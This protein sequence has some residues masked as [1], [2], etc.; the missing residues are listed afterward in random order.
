MNGLKLFQRICIHAAG[1]I[2]TEVKDY[3]PEKEHRK[4]I[5]E[6]R[7]LTFILAISAAAAIWTWHPLPILIVGLPTIYGAWLFIFFCV[8]QHA[9]LQEYVLDHRL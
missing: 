6:A 4:V 8:T 9:G 2:D 1:K 5:W 3:L 7:V